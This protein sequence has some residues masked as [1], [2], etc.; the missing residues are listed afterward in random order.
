MYIVIPKMYTETR[1]PSCVF[2]PTP[3]TPGVAVGGGADV[4]GVAVGGGADV[5]GVADR[6]TTTIK[7]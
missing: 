4:P 6:A 1:T 5:P 7:K 2:I 3:P